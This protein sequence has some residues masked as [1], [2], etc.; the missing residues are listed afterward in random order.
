MDLVALRNADPG[1]L[2]T[3]AGEWLAMEARLGRLA[4]QFRSGTSDLLG[5]YWAGAAADAAGTHLEKVWS[6]LTVTADDMAAMAVLC[7]DG[8]K[9]ISGAQALLRLAEDVAAENRLVIGADGSVTPPL[10]SAVCLPATA[11]AAAQAAQAAVEASVRK[12]AALV[13][14]ALALADETDQRVAAGLGA[15]PAATLAAASAA[16]A[17]AS[18]L[19]GKLGTAMMPPA[20]LSP[21]QAHAWWQALDGPARQQLIHQFPA[22]IGWMN[23]L[24]AGARS[25]AN[26]IAMNQAQH[27]L[28]GQLAQLEAHPPAGGWADPG[29]EHAWQG[30]ISRIKQELAGIAGIESGLKLGGVGGA[31]NALLLG[32]STAGNGHA[33]VS[34]GNPDTSV[35]TVTYVPGVGTTMAKAGGDCQRAVTL[36]QQAH[37]ADPG[38]SVASVYWLDYNAPQP[39]LPGAIQIPQTGDAVAG[40]HS[41]AGFQAGLGAAHAAGIPDRTVLLGHSYGSLVVGEAMAHDGLRPTDVI[42]VGSPGVGVS[43]AAQL[44]IPAGH[45]WAGANINDPVPDLTPASG[46]PTVGP[47]A[48]AGATAGGLTGGAVS[49]VE[50]AWN[51]LGKTPVA[52][53][54]LTSAIAFDNALNA[55]VP[56]VTHGATQGA[57]NG[58]MTPIWEYHVQHPDAGYFGTNPATPAFGG[59]GFAANY[60]PG[61]PSTFNLHYFETFKAHSSYW[62]SK[63]ASLANLGNI[64]TGQYGN[65]TLSG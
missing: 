59:H 47:Q 44:G 48:A 65:V 32:F 33:I 46:L 34:F 14:R 40:G 53:G 4:A 26:I 38:M 17:S 42:F 55:V 25:Q 63:S 35:T 37:T 45:V 62:A 13:A 12:A 43:H 2:V 1:L 54:D 41:L 8:A 19:A 61:E 58:A 11:P 16:L 51:L 49:A 29:A 5:Q 50:A 28:N 24:P 31:P 15:L 10:S 39:S 22:Q 30:Q 23:G 52:P 18:G 21:A 36:W 64:V 57:M 6:G 3:A 9:G 7:Q 27:D 56:D 60:V 20:R